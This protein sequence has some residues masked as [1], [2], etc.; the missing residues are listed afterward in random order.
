MTALVPGLLL[1]LA[2]GVMPSDGGIGHVGGFAKTVT[3]LV[4]NW[5]D[6]TSAENIFPAMLASKKGKGKNRN[7][8]NQRRIRNIE[9]TTQNHPNEV[10]MRRQA[11]EALAIQED[12]QNTAQDYTIDKQNNRRAYCRG[13]IRVFNDQTILLCNGI[14]RDVS[15]NEFLGMTPQQQQECR[16]K[17]PNLDGYCICPDD[18]GPLEK[19]GVLSCD[20]YAPVNC[21]VEMLTPAKCPESTYNLD[22]MKPCNYYNTTDA[23]TVSMNLTCA[24]QIDVANNRRII[25]DNKFFWET[26]YIHGNATSLSVNTIQHIKEEILKP[27][28]NGINKPF[29]MTRTHWLYQ[30]NV[31]LV[32]KLYNFN[33]VS[34]NAWKWETTFT[35]MSAVPGLV[36]GEVP[37]DIKLDFSKVPSRFFHSGRIYAE[38]GLLF[39]SNHT[40]KMFFDFPEYKPPSY[41]QG[42]DTVLVLTIV[43]G[44]MSLYVINVLLST[45][46]CPIYFFGEKKKN[47]KKNS[48]LALVVAAVCFK[49]SRNK[50]LLGRKT[51]HID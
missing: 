10:I 49:H 45:V 51:L 23:I 32:F 20:F 46:V 16:L 15:N 26:R 3:K 48:V 35:D 25:T 19:D 9:K 41:T 8:N 31:G 42:T 7:K 17:D 30:S 38:A 28:V 33:R 24:I 29:G 36:T 47:L 40:E 11:V 43:V 27:V 39:S 2:A 44:V 22:W 12:D 37:L 14:D 1:S 21:T 50:D 13:G 4:D 5:L 6:S 18:S 34:D